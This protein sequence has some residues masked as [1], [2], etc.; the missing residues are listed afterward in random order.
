MRKTGLSFKTDPYIR[1]FS[2]DE[3]I[4]YCKLRYPLEY[5]DQNPVSWYL[6]LAPLKKK[7]A[8]VES[9]YFKYLGTEDLFR[10]FIV[11]ASKHNCFSWVLCFH[12]LQ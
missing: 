7:G 6:V 12:E 9:K 3:N 10:T 4:C 1:C 2:A 11:T 8:V 5:K